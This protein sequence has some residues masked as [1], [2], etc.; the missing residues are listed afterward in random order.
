VI[1]ATTKKCKKVQKSAQEYEKKGDR[2]QELGDSGSEEL[3]PPYPTP[4]SM[5]YEYQKKRLT[6]VSE[7]PTSGSYREAARIEMPNTITSTV[8]ACN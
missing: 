5:M 1:F 4:P 3:A 7:W 6:K 8:Y 2:V